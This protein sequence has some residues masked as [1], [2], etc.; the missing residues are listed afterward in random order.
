[1]DSFLASLNA[2]SAMTIPLLV[3]L[4]LRA[5]HVLDG[6]FSQSVSTLIYS[7]CLPISLACS[8][9]SGDLQSARLPL[10][11][12]AYA[13]AVLLLT[14]FLLCISVRKKVSDPAKV[15]SIVQGC[16]RGNAS[17]Y[18]I[19][20]GMSLYGN[21]VSPELSLIM[22][23]GVVFFNILSVLTF[24]LC[25]G[26]KMTLR[27]TL[28]SVM[29]NPC[30]CG[31]LLGLLLNTLD[32]E[33]PKLIYQPLSAIGNIVT[34]L[35]FI[36][37]GTT[38]RFS[39]THKNRRLAGFITLFKLILLPTVALCGAVLLGFRG[40]ALVGLLAV[41]ATPCAV[42][43]YPMALKLGGDGPLAAQAIMYS[44]LFSAVTIFSFI[45]VLKSAC[46]I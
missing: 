27:R 14:F 32:V 18:G 39:G 34:P 22:L 7:V 3:G 10:G 43:S 12:I 41:F 21:I 15:G 38:F 16:F 44:T 40:Q 33:I 11:A 31:I 23:V 42:G 25:S 45:Y 28:I 35:C 26:A 36:A 29:K 8:M 1:M 9:Y 6:N 17:I 24:A 20:L 2:V 30:I 19:P 37:I 4:L 46:L 5:L 13:A